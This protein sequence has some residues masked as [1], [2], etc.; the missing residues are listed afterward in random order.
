[1]AHDRIRVLDTQSVRGT[2]IRLPDERWA[3]IA[4]EHGELAGA[5]DRVLETVRSPEV[6]HEGANGELLAV[7]PSVDGKSLVVVYRDDGEDGFVI[8]AFL[9]SRMAQLARRPQLWP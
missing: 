2:P 6:V 8:T 5:R 7:S 4:L 1:V 3:H 9:T